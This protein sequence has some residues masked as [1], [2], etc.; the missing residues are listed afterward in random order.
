MCINYVYITTHTF[1][2]ICVCVHC[3][4]KFSTALLKIQNDL[5][6][7]VAK[8]CTLVA[9]PFPRDCSVAFHFEQY[10]CLYRC[11]CLSWV[12]EILH[13]TALDPFRASG[14]MLLLSMVHGYHI[15]ICLLECLGVRIWNHIIHPVNSNAMCYGMETYYNVLSLC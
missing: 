2:Y 6:M 3:V 8:Y 14:D 13:W 7:E 10:G 11:T 9:V 1:R 5:R 15:K 12:S 4:S